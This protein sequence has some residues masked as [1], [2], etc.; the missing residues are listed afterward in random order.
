MT[1]DDA[2]SESLLG[3][4]YV[5][6]GEEGGA[7]K[8]LE[9]VRTA[10]GRQGQIVLAL[11]GVETVEQAEAL[12]DLLVFLERSQLP[13]LGEDEYWQ[14]DLVG[15]LAVGEDGEEVGEVMEVVDTAEV[16]VLVVRKGREE[17]FV[18]FN[19]THVLK[20]DLPGRSVVVAPPEAM[21]S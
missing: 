17:T 6:L 1:L 4:S 19:K 11:E 2:K 18:P 10:K 16:P 8:R 5:H 7:L 15:L 12:R 20:V 3:V 21:E 9:T 14:R 13:A